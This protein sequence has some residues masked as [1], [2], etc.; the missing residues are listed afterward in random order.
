MWPFAVHPI[1]FS[2]HHWLESFNA[3]FSY[4]FW[5][6]LLFFCYKIKV[7]PLPRIDLSSLRFYSVFK[8]QIK[9][10]LYEILPRECVLSSNKW[11]I[12]GLLFY[13]TFSVW[14][15]RS[16]GGGMHMLIAHQAPLSM[17]F[18]IFRENFPGKNVLQW[19]A[20]SFS[21]GSSQPRDRI[22][23]LSPA[24]AGGFFTTSATWEALNFQSKYSVPSDHWLS[25]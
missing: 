5:E 16:A 11:S 15:G 20:I 21:R 2:P 8:A 19:V 12:T 13:L 10:H 25:Y 1:F 7:F 17:E 18:F 9:F 4:Y 23:L 14:W 6:I 3:G 24:L 22:Y